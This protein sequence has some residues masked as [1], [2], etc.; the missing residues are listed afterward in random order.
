MYLKFSLEDNR[1]DGIR[2]VSADLHMSIGHKTVLVYIKMEPGDT[3]TSHILSLLSVV[4][5]SL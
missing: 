5:L 4:S 1:A 3:A 2:R